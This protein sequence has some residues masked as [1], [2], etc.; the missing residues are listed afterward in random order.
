MYTTVDL[1]AVFISTQIFW[2][3]YFYIGPVDKTNSIFM[4][5][6][7]SHNKFREVGEE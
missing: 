4:L 3:A 6:C 1:I 7:S 5:F 2:K